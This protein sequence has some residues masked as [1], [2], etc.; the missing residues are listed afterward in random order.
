MDIRI[1]PVTGPEI[2]ALLEEHLAH[3]RAI[4]PPESVHALDLD[5]LRAPELT[6]WTAWRDGALL[7]C[8]A[9]KA[10]DPSHGE[11]KSMRTATG[12]RRQGIA[13]GILETIL[14]TAEQR[15]YRRLSLETGATDHFAPARMLY[16]RYGFVPC[17]PFGDYQPDP[18]SAFMT[19]VMG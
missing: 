4:T 1:D 5:G 7:G 8:G 2:I 13:A 15:G 11:I 14:S 12:L 18:H 6:M 10:L 3:M 17:G 19:K 16:A 9:L